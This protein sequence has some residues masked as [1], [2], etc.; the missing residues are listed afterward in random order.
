LPEA[1]AYSL[2]AGL[3]PDHAIVGA[4][5]GLLVYA[6]VGKSRYAI[7]A[8]T[9]SS[10]AILAAAVASIPVSSS[11]EKLALAFGLVLFTGVA[12]AAA[13]LARLGHLADFISR[14]VLRGFAFGLAA[15]IV[16]KQLPMIAGVAA[17]GDPWQI[18][19]SL[20]QQ[21]G[22]WNQL[23]LAIGGVALVLLFAFKWLPGVPGAFVVLALF[24]GASMAGHFCEQGVACVGAID[25]TLLAP[26]IP[27]VS[28]QNWSR[29]A[30][31]AAPMT[32]IIYAESWGSMRTYA[33]RHGENLD[34]NRE[35]ISL[36]LAN[37]TSGLMRGMPVGAGFSA[38]SANEAAGAR[39]R[40]SGVVAAIAIVL[41]VALGGRY[42]ALL[43][44][45]ALAAVVVAALAHA[46]DPKPLIHLWRIDRDQYVATVA[47]LAV[48]AFGVLNGMLIAV[49]LS[50]IAVIQ[51][52][53]D[54]MVVV[55]GRYRDTHDFVDIRRHPE[56][57]AHAEIAV[58]RPAAPLFFT[59][60]ERVVAKIEKIIGRDAS[61]KIVILSVEES[62]DLDS[63]ALD[64]LCE[65]DA[66]LSSS[67]KTLY[68][69]RVKDRAREL[70][71]R[72]RANYLAAPDRG[73]FSVADAFEA[74][75]AKL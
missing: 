26:G 12:F 61:T 19:F 30:Q 60:S 39:S 47:A 41:L 20:F 31:L 62:D 24:I 9:S 8:P 51:R 33:L 67:G 40:L 6:I 73:F 21:M 22:R 27:S 65:F 45:A 1:V 70:L 5:I 18:L 53:S 15:T 54:P 75:R 25:V 71:Q 69:A 59:N 13:G 66:R 14:P 29:L 46:L 56:A 57:L 4:V 3:T 72:S 37:L 34:A 64:V 16:I 74:A 58:F 68:L 11:D 10:A 23:S 28:M 63:T 48:L 17:R 7:T 35:L 38:T 36:G 49:G 55:L 50:L 2:I 43:P 44:E 52:F 42:I 32:L